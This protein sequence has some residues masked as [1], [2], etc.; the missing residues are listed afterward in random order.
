MLI[1]ITGNGSKFFVIN[2]GF[3]EQTKGWPSKPLDKA[4]QWLK[5]KP[6][7]WRVADLGC[8]EAML[9]TQ[10]TQRVD[11]FDLIAKRPEVVACNMASL[12]LPD[13]C[14]DAA[15][16]CLSLMG[17]DYGS[18]IE[19][20]T[21]VLKGNGWIWIAEVQSRFV[22]ESGRNVLK[23]FVKQFQTLGFIVKRQ[24]TSNS[25]FVIMEFQRND[26][27]SDVSTLQWPALRACQYKKR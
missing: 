10:V 20:A 11:S 24:D 25:H 27:S 3:K 13:S 21:R 8:G 17:T 23:S 1:G 12:P 15:I 7:S 9:A 22:D 19:E 16:F 5:G 4:I 2:S 6:K 14:I 18:F 26:S